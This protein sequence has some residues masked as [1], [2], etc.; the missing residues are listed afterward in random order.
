MYQVVDSLET[1]GSKNSAAH[2]QQ[3]MVEKGHRRERK[4]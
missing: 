2:P 1:S 4:V 3:S